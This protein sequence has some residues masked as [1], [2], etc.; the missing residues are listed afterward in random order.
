M[1]ELDGAPMR[2]T[3]FPDRTVQIRKLDKGW[4]A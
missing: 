4:S 2:P 1:I 3:T